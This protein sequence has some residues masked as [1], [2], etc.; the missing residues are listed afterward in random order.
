MLFHIRLQ[1]HVNEGLATVYI[2][3][4]SGTT[5]HRRNDLKRPEESTELIQLDGTMGSATAFIEMLVLTRGRTVKLFQGTPER[6]KDVSFKN[7]RL[8]GGLVI[9]TALKG[10]KLADVAVSSRFGGSLKT[11]ADGLS[12]SF[13]F[14]AGES[15]SLL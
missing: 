1:I 8:P 9:S 4:S 13:E 10:G 6:W 5:A 2:P 11:E 15:S 12:G 3:R 7:V 14:L